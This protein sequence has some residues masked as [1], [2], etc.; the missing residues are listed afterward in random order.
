MSEDLKIIYPLNMYRVNQ[1]RINK[2][3]TF[4]SW[5]YNLLRKN[6]NFKNYKK[7][8]R[9]NCKIATRRSNKISITQLKN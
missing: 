2:L 1:T 4:N 6:I 5:E 8:I 3:M 9:R 7:K